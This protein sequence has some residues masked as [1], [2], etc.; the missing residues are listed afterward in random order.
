MWPVP[1]LVL[2]RA[3]PLVRLSYESVCD[4]MRHDVPVLIARVGVNLGV[5]GAGELLS[6]PR[7]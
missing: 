7:P 4:A 2:V 5:G 3:H 6:G 1:V